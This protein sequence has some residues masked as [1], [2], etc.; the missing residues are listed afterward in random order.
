MKLTILQEKLKEGLNVVER[1]VSKSLTLPILNNVL[2]R[3]SKNFLTLSA[4][5]LEIGIN[6][7]TLAM[8]EEEGAVIIPSQAISGLINLFP[9]K[10]ISIIS[11]GLTVNISCESHK[12]SSRGLD[13]DEF[14]I[15]PSIVGGESLKLAASSFCQGLAQVVNIAALS[16]TKPEISGV[17]FNFQQDAFKMVATD[18]FRLGEKTIFLKKAGGSAVVR[19][20]ILPQRT[21]REIINI[22]GEEEGE[23]TVY[24]SPNQVLFE[25]KM[26]ETDAPKIQLISR[27]IEGEF[28]NYQE[29]IP[30]KYETQVILPKKEFLN[31][32]KSASIFSGKTNEVKLA[33]NPTKGQVQVSSQDQDLGEYQSELPVKVRGKGLE[34]AFNCKFLA[35]GILNMPGKTEG[36]ILELTGEEGAAVLKPE[37]DQEYL[38]VL[39]PIKKT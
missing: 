10:P 32:T 26:A 3:A 8:V 15:I 2:I 25:S 36:V 24:F 7:Q 34:I 33:I 29:I 12:S 30:K 16:T 38:Y 22:F 31:Q 9:N 14:P 13:P 37:G 6:W 4:T 19:N 28:P 1:I 21:A 17:Y 18:S 39:M 35:E 20:F 11:K 27:L 23:I 5:D